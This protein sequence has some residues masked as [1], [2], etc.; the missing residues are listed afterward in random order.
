MFS[1]S[2][3]FLCQQIPEGIG[4]VGVGGFEKQSFSESVTSPR[5]VVVA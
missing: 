5:A 3:D 2:R 1:Y 4:V